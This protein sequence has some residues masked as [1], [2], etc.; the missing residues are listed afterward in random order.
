MKASLLLSEIKVY[1]LGCLC[2]SEDVWVVC[3]CPTQA[4]MKVASLQFDQLFGASERNVYLQLTSPNASGEIAIIRLMTRQ[5][6]PARF[7]SKLRDEMKKNSFFL[8]MLFLL[9]IL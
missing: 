3:C 9:Y 7:Y 4:D 2:V 8:N 6:N 5:Q 1:S